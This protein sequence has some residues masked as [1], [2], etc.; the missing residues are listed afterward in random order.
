M[1]PFF[2]AWGATLG[3]H[4][5]LDATAR[6]EVL[7]TLLDAHEADPTQQGFLRAMAGMHG[8]VRG[9]LDEVAKGL[10]AKQRRAV[11]AGLV[12]EAIGV[13]AERFE[14]RMVNRFKQAFA[15]AK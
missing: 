1:G 8:A 6:A 15:A 9:G 4:P 2:D 13:G 10:P 11:A 14:A 5:S 7:A 3:R 12:R